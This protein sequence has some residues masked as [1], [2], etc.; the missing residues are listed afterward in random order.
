MVRAVSAVI[1]CSCRD[2]LVVVDDGL[3]PQLVDPVIAPGTLA[4]MRQPTLALADFALRPWQASDAPAV[5]EAF[6]E[7]TIRRWHVRWMTAD[8]ALLW[9]DSWA[10]RWSQESAAG[11][12]IADASGLLGQV[13]LRRLSLVDGL[14]AVSY[15]V[16]PAARGRG[17]AR[18]ALGALT[19]WAFEKL[20]LHRLELTHSTANPVSCRVAANAGYRLEGTKR[21][22]GR[23]ADGWHDMHLHAR[24]AD[25][26][27]VTSTP[28][29]AR[30]TDGSLCLHA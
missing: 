24:L 19:G 9:V 1:E 30:C 15:W 2:W 26:P 12:A 27:P 8:E 17:V 28:S 29:L 3:V 4:R 11:W 16:M 20:G 14:A 18:Q 21:Q 10:G 7:P 22:E 5:V 13:G 6:A 23:H 25:D